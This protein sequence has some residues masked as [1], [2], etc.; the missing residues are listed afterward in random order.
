MTRAGTLSP[1]AARRVFRAPLTAASITSFTVA[2]CACAASRMAPRSASTVRTWRRGPVARFSEDLGAGSGRCWPSS[3][4]AA[5]RVAVPWGI[6]RSE[7]RRLADASASSCRH[8]GAG[9]GRGI[10]AGMGPLAAASSTRAARTARPPMPSATT[11]CRTSTTAAVLSLRSVT[12]TARQSGRER[13]SGLV[14]ISTAASR[15]AAW[16]PGCRHRTCSTWAPTSKRGSS[17]QIGRPQP[18]GTSTSRWRR[19]GIAASR[20]SSS[21]RAPARSKPGPA[22]R[23]RTAP[24]FIGTGPTSVANAWTSPGPIRSNHADV[25]TT[26]TIPHPPSIV[27]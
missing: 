7:C 15:S 13:S 19:R 16:S 24:T 21:I 17:T 4:T 27:R 12:S 5:L 1:R 9:R 10:G 8:V 25:L 20:A 11:W 14:T 18:N 6:R 2:P 23:V 3:A 26:P 22:S